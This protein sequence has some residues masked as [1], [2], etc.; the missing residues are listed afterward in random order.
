MGQALS[1]I[2][3]SACI[4]CEPEDESDQNPLET[5]SHVLIYP[6]I[7]PFQTI[8]RTEFLQTN[9][10]EYSCIDPSITTPVSNPPPDHLSDLVSGDSTSNTVALHQNLLISPPQSSVLGY[11]QRDSRTAHAI[12]QDTSTLFSSLVSEKSIIISDEESN[13]KEPPSGEKEEGIE[14]EEKVVLNK[15]VLVIEEILVSEESIISD[16]ESNLKE[17]PPWEKEEGM[18]E[19]EKVVINKAVLVIEERWIKHYSSFQKILLVGEGDFSFSASLAMAF[20]SAHNIVATSLNTAGYLSRNYRS[21][22]SNIQSL[23][24]RGAKVMHDVD[25]TQM[26]GQILFQGMTFDRIVFNFPLSGFFSDDSRESKLRRERK[27]VRH[28]IANAREMIAEEGEIH[29]THKSNGFFRQWNLEQLA[30]SAGLQLIDET[31]CRSRAFSL[32]SLSLFKLDQSRALRVRTGR[33]TSM[34]IGIEYDAVMR[35]EEREE[36]EIWVKYYCSSHKILLVGEGDFSFSL[37]LAQSFGS[38]SNIVASS[39]DSYD[40]LIK[41]YKQAESNLVKL[42]KLGAELFHG[43][44]A[45]TMK[46]HTDLKM[47]KFNRIIFNFPHAG[48]Y[49]KEDDILLIMMHRYVVHGFL[50]N[51]RG[52]LGANGEIHINHKTTFP[53]NRWNLVELASQNCLALIGYVDF[54]AEDYPGYKNKRGEGPG[55]TS[56][57]GLNHSFGQLGISTQSGSTQHLVSPNV[58]GSVQSPPVQI[59][60]HPGSSSFHVPPSVAYNEGCAL[61]LPQVAASSPQPWEQCNKEAEMHSDLDLV[62]R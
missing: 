46:L 33:E 21:A 38:A 45:T 42:G 50:R 25:A 1:N 40:D 62:I 55:S 35:A 41:K 34:A 26:A 56:Y 30:S 28:F 18:E 9:S 24:S 61:V 37:S 47:R 32:S 36:R 44:D 8:T 57:N 17:P 31:F 23:R 48:F 10:S 5:S 49:G 20:G 16:E 58:F 27:L 39:L 51:A 53:Y 11:S 59:I 52:M 22:M 19:G 4:C 2:L 43:V 29:V 7:P 14:E 15:A 13:L 12:Q 54:K 60:G 6:S 3:G